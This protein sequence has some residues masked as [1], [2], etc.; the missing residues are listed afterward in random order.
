MAI[1]I[2]LGSDLNRSVSDNVRSSFRDLAEISNIR[3]STKQTKAATEDILTKLEDF[4]A[5]A[6]KR[7][8]ERKA[9]IAEAKAREQRA[10]FEIA[11]PVA[12]EDLYKLNRET[13]FIKSASEASQEE[14]NLTYNI[15]TR[16]MSSQQNLDAANTLVQRLDLPVNLPKI[17]NNETRES[18]L[19]RQQALA[20]SQEY[21]QRAALISDNLVAQQNLQSRAAQ[22]ASKQSTQDFWEAFLLQQ[23][24]MEGRYKIALSKSGPKLKEP[25]WAD[26]GLGDLGKWAAEAGR[27]LTKGYLAND[28]LSLDSRGWNSGQQAELE[29]STSLAAE[30]QSRWTRA[31]NDFMAGRGQA[32]LHPNAYHR[33]VYMD[34][35]NPASATANK[36]VVDSEDGS[37]RFISSARSELERAAVEQ[38]MQRDISQQD[39][40]NIAD[41]VPEFADMNQ[42]DQ[43]QLIVDLQREIMEESK[44]AVDPSPAEI[45]P[46]GNE[47][48]RHFTR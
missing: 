18:M 12:E 6:E 37:V 42:E 30:A 29:L 8:A 4:K 10:G 47:Y 28:K 48:D 36:L 44:E 19:G 11:D 3:A 7:S 26:T 40:T 45:L 17:L 35:L 46:F 21:R 5:G 22:I 1:P 41:I 16:A 38:G 27:H 23:A 13:A 24:E 34:Y 32:P 43:M 9:Q 15:L 25:K 2:L 20:K 31:K 39:M 14:N 33:Q